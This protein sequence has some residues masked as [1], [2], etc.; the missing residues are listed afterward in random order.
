MPDYIDKIK[1]KE[2]NSKCLEQMKL[3]DMENLGCVQILRV[4]GGWIY[5]ICNFSGEVL[6]TEFVPKTTSP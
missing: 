3:H 5:Y 1:A 4:W 6:S 2:I